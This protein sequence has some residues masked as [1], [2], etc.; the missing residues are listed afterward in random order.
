M[1]KTTQKRRLKFRHLK[2]LDR[3]RLEGLLRAGHNQETAAKVLGMAPSTISREIRQH[4][5]KTGVYRATAAQLK[6]NVKRSR[7]KY[8]GMKIEK[9]LPLQALVIAGL[10]AHR[11]PDEM[12]GRLSRQGFS[13]GKNAIYKWLYSSYGQRYCP[14]LCT[15]RYRRRQQRLRARR[16]LIPNRLPLMFRPF[17]SG[18]IH[19]EGDTALSPKQ[20]R[21]K[22]AAVLLSKTRSKLILGQ[23][24][25]N[26][27]PRLVARAMAG[28]MTGVAADT[29]A[30]DNGQ[31]NRDHE[32]V[33]VQIYFCDPYAPWQ[34]ARVENSIGLLRRWFVPKGTD[35]AQVGEPELKKY[36][37]ILNGKY[38]KALNYQSAYEVASACGIIKQFKPL[39]NCI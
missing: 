12:A 13:L 17:G 6:A 39:E 16:T 31:E 32:Q 37:H 36:R 3:D 11:S 35:W 34:K 14:Y 38:R 29:L 2:Q 22:A 4:R 18:L 25:A 15:R 28:L 27:R 26:R 9:D 7:S 24:V 23:K 21:S 10:Q 33:G 20:S 8:Q 5:L 1:V 30:L 19:W